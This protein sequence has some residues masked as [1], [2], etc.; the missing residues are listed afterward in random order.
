MK[1]WLKERWAKELNRC[2]VLFVAVLGVNNGIFW[3]LYYNLRQKTSTWPNQRLATLEIDLKTQ[4]GTLYESEALCA[5]LTEQHDIAI[6]RSMFHA[7]LFSHYI[8]EHFAALSVTFAC[9]IL[10]A[11]LA[12]AIVRRGWDNTHKY[13][14]TAFVAFTIGVAFFGGY[15]KLA[16]HE[17]NLKDNEFL[18]L[19]HGNLVS[20]IRSF[21]ATGRSPG[22][23]ETEPVEDLHDFIH[24]T[25][26]KLRKYN[27]IPLEF[28]ANAVDF[29]SAKFMELQPE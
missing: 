21:C 25:D 13:I 27:R 12:A 6:V 28:D 4:C 7:D 8:A 5:R 19:A 24:Q 9:S 23:E 10:A 15:P 2:A 29:G 17:D 26:V 22:D 3:F 16:S 14:R 18:F 20:E 1:A 11:A